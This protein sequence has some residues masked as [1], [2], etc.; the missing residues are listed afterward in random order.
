[1]NATKFLIVISFLFSSVACEGTGKVTPETKARASQTIEIASDSLSQFN[2][3]LE[4][5]GGRWPISSESIDYLIDGGML[6]SEMPDDIPTDNEQAIKG[7]RNKSALK[8]KNCFDA[9]TDFQLTYF[10]LTAELMKFRNTSE[11]A[12]RDLLQK[13]S[14]DLDKVKKDCDLPG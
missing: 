5:E 8:T 2:S 7:L 11:Q 4:L 13:L 10:E 9:T 1:M 12:Q 6:F 14:I 3:S